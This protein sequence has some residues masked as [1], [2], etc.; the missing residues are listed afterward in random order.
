MLFC[1][2]AVKPKTAALH[3]RNTAIQRMTPYPVRIRAS[4]FACLPV[5]KGPQAGISNFSLTPLVMSYLGQE[6]M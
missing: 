1:R 2:V 3:R 5:G 6:E 4:I